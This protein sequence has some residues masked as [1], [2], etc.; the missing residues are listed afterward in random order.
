MAKHVTLPG[1]PEPI[2]GHQANTLDIESRLCRQLE[3]SE[4]EDIPPELLAEERPRDLEE[5]SDSSVAYEVRHVRIPILD[6]PTTTS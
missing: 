6:P 5:R 2:V 3:R 1:P 4:F